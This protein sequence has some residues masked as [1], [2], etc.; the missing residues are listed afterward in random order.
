MKTTMQAEIPA[1]LIELEEAFNRAMIS[2]DVEQI[3]RCI[4]DD[5]IL[6]T[7]EAGPVSRSRILG[8]IGSGLLTHAT[9]SKVATHACV[10]GDMAWVTGRGQN[11]GTFNGKP[12]TADEYI[13]D[14]YRRVDG[15]WRCMLTHLTPAHGG[16]Q[17][18]A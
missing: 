15:Q 9:M 4:T 10:A 5:W 8:V 7:P 2:N 11:T 14:I 18:G 13:T 6:V 12:M 3:S 17:G 16:Q 1:F